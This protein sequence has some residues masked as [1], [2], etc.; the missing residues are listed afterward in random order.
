MNSRHHSDQQKYKD[1][2]EQ[3]ARVVGE[4]MSI[5][6]DFSRRFS[7]GFSEP[8]PANDDKAHNHYSESR[9]SNNRT[10]YNA[11]EEFKQAGEYLRELREAAGYSIDGFAQ[12]MNRQNA[13]NKIESVEAGRDVFP[14]DWLDQISAL[15]KQNDPMEFFDKLRSLYETEQRETEQRETEQRD[16]EQS[17]GGSTDY[18]ANEGDSGNFDSNIYN[19]NNRKF[20]SASAVVSNR[21]E[22]LNE[23]FTDDTLEGLSD[24]QFD[25]LS[26]F[27]KTNYHAALQLVGRKSAD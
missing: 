7:S 26:D 18:S 12:A 4:F 16:T 17:V 20:Q 24:S 21:R 8:N 23:I 3:A 22:K 15:L 5:A 14:N 11:T 10:Q 27:I 13:A 6:N 9:N 1:A 25:E 19:S 2:G